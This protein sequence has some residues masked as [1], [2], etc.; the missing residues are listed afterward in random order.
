[1]L[2]AAPVVGSVEAGKVSIVVCHSLLILNL[3]HHIFASL[4]LSFGLVPFVS[5]L[6][7][8]AMLMPLVA[9]SYLRRRA[10]LSRH[11]LTLLSP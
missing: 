3:L 8:H 6:I 11:Q 9:L 5:A 1:M 4:I 7:V 2:I 10:S